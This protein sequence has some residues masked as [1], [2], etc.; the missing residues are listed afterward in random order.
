M[1][2]SLLVSAADYT[3]KYDSRQT[4]FCQDW[5]VQTNNIGSLQG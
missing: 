3:V 2:V 4:S 1:S 5:N